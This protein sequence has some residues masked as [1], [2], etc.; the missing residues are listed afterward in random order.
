M[1]GFGPVAP[2]VLLLVVLMFRPHGLFGRPDIDR[3]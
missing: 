2:L 3:V 1:P